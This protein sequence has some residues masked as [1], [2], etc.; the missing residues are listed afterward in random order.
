M[1]PYCIY[2]HL[3]NIFYVTKQKQKIYMNKR[4]VLT[5][6]SITFIISPGNR[7]LTLFSFL[8]ISII[9]LV[10][11]LMFWLLI[12]KLLA[13]G[14]IILAVYCTTKVASHPLVQ[15]MFWCRFS[16]SSTCVTPVCF[17]IAAHGL[18]RKYKYI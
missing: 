3:P 1:L 11:A 10:N 5:S 14:N 2:R 7:T 18:Y 13:Y 16:W 17:A 9:L 4:N 8:L 15:A 6:F 12:S